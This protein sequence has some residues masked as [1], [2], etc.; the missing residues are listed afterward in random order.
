MNNKTNIVVIDDEETML[1]VIERTLRSDGFTVHTFSDPRAGIERIRSGGIDL[2]I[3]DLM[4]DSMNGFAVVNEAMTIKKDVMVIVITAFSSVESA[5]KAMK[6]GAYDFIPK[7]FDPEHLLLVVRRG[8]DSIK[9]RQENIVLKKELKKNDPFQALTGISRPMQDLK[10]L[11][12]KVRSTDGTVLITGESGVGKELVARA[13]HFGSDRGD[14]RFIP[15]NCGALPDELLESELFGYEKGAF[16]GAV[17]NKKGLLELADRGT[18]F[19]DEM[20]SISPMMQVKLLRFLQDRSFIRLGGGQVITVDV[21]VIS[22]TNEDLTECIKAGRFRKDLFYRLNVIPVRVPSLAERNDDI[23]LLAR[24]FIEKYNRK[25]GKKICGLTSEAEKILLAS[26]WEGNVRELENCMERA[27]TLGENEMITAGDIADKSDDPDNID[28]CGS[29][30]EDMSMAELEQ[31]HL[32][33][34]VAACDG[35]KS[36]AAKILKIDY[37]T[38]LRKLK[39]HEFIT[40]C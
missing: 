37:T 11:I 29:Y 36:Q 10:K 34:V 24:S 15:I 12:N 8:L 5:V 19:L 17:G 30:S 40:E 28:G 20:E 21:R 13:I 27:V 16:S 9:L 4:M 32:D 33:N 1:R 23:L 18:V 35:N 14:K 25:T 22:A 39:K 7:P 26:R 31:W 38:L 3:T 6:L 2:V